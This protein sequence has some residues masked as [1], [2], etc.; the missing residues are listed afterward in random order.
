[1]SVYLFSVPLA[2]GK[3]DTWK[4]YM[5][6]LTGPRHDDY[7]KSRKR[8]GLE[9]EQVFLQQTPHGDMCVVRWETDNPQQTFETIAKSDEPFDK[10]FRDKVLIECHDMDLSQ[11]MPM[12]KQVVDLQVTPTREFA[13]TQKN[14]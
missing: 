1:M 11:A 5:K 13:G 9:V 2:A 4:K 10:W 3:T 12:N 7:V 14:R 8:L 6:E